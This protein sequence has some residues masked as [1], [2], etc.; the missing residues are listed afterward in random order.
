M[1]ITHRDVRWVA[2]AEVIIL[3]VTLRGHITALRAADLFRGDYIRMHSLIGG[4]CFGHPYSPIFIYKKA[5]LFK[6]IDL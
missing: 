6:L 2:N 5:E 3:V 1:V 4:T